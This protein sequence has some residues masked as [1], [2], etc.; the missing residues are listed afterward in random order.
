MMQKL[1]IGPGQSVR[2]PLRRSMVGQRGFSL[3]SAIFLLV[4]LSAL[5]AA[6]VKVTSSSQ[7]TAA[8]DIQGERAY[9]AARAGIEWGLYRQLRQKSC[10]AETTFALPDGATVRSTLAGFTVTVSC[11]LSRRTFSGNLMN[12]TA[13]VSD[14]ADTGMLEPG[15]DVSGPGIPA[16]TKIVSVNSST[17][18]TLSN[19]ATVGGVQEIRYQSDLDTYT[20]KSIACNQPGANGACP[21]DATSNHP[22]YVQRVLEV[23]F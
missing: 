3:F 15:M 13:V 18:L 23:R 2:H 7:I 20:L 11:A 6:I 22:D 5:G 19:A 16:D 17:T 4:M 8:L 14:V 1:P 9:Q 10:T 21:H 12:G